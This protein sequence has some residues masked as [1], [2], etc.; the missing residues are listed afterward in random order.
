MAGFRL[1]ALWFLFAVFST[2]QSATFTVNT[3]SDGWDFTPVVVFR[4]PGKGPFP[5]AVINHGS[6][7]NGDNPALFTETFTAPF[8]ADI[9]NERGWLVAF[10]Q[11]RGRGKSNGVYDEG[12]SADRAQGYTCDAAITLAGAD[13]ALSD[14]EAAIAAL[15]SRPDISNSRIL[16]GGVSRGG[17]LSVAYAGQHPDKIAGVLNFVG[18]WLGDS[19]KSAITVNRD[20]FRRGAQFKGSMLWMYGQGDPFYAMSHSRENFSAFKSA[21][22]HGSFLEFDVPGGDGHSVIGHP[23]LWMT[24][25]GEYLNL[26]RFEPR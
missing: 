18:G 24:P 16:I 9:L 21:G 8:F 17:V 4:P 5:L 19:C 25:V 10:P 15:S 22:G 20:L 1:V 26:L 12:F 14:I 2:A 11:R 6:T 7:A 13:R 3:T 23:P